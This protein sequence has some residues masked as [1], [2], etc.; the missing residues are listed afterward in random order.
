MRLLSGGI[1][2]ALLCM[3]VVSG[4]ASAQGT[5]L[6]IQPVKISHTLQPGGSVSGTIKVVNESPEDIRLEVSVE[7]FVPSAGTTNVSFVGRAEGNTT[8]RDWIELD[9][10]DSQVFKKGER[11][12]VPYTIRAP[13][14]A[15]PGGHFGVAFFNALRIGETGNLKVGTRI[16]TLFFVTIPG[17]QLQKGRI[18]EFTAPEFQQE[19]PVPFTITFE[20]TG[21]VH[22]E[23]KGEIVIT[24]LLGKEVGTVQ[25]SGQA[26]LPTQVRDLKAKWGAEGPLLG[27]Y[28]ASLSMTDGEGNELTADEIVFYGFPLWYSLII[29]IAL[30]AVFFLIRFVRRYVNISVS[31]NRNER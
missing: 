20:N 1:L 7:D 5:G 17:N 23:P 22:F 19:G 4:S 25:V 8:V 10:P 29:V 26:V 31:V 12:N 18:L 28:T 6:T 2:L 11:I 24:N 14:D 16:G 27:R 9:I 21:T 3:G 13:E 30:V 15:E